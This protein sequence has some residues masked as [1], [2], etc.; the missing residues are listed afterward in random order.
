MTPL[1]E[2]AKKHKKLSSFIGW[3]TRVFCLRGKR[4]V[5]LSAKRAMFKK[6]RIIS[7]RKNN[8]LVIGEYSRITGCTFKFIGSNHTMIIGDTVALNKVTLM[9]SGDGGTF[10]IGRHTSING[11]SHY[12]CTEGCTVEIGSDCLIAPGVDLASGDG[13]SIITAD[14][15][16]RINH[17]KPI[18]IGNH[19]WICSNVQ[20]LKNFEIGDDSVI[21][22]KSV[23]SSRHFGSNVVVVG[24]PAKVVKEGINWDP[25]LLP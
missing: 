2:F 13:H 11:P 4:K 17:S 8:K 19:V 1:L 16:E 3:V 7:T 14:K 6:C 15:K 12:H 10:T 23:C 20:I 18:K 24:Q 25:K 21:G 9:M 5:S 22:A